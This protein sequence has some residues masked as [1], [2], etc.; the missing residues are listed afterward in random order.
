MVLFTYAS[1]W[2][3]SIVYF[4]HM[5]L[6]TYV[7]EISLLVNMEDQ[8]YNNNTISLCRFVEVR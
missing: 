2:P 3:H 5:A 7:N 6:F 1:I 4:K 8:P